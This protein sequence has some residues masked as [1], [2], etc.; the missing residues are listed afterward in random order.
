MGGVIT[1]AATKKRGRPTIHSDSLKEGMS[2]M[3]PGL[4]ERSL[5]NL[6]FAAG[7][8]DVAEQLLGKDKASR[9]FLHSPDEPCGS[10]LYRGQ[11]ILEQVGRMKLQDGYSDND[12]KTIMGIALRLRD[13][14][15]TVRDVERW[16]RNGRTTGVF[17]SEA[18]TENKEG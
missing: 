4:S 2:L 17:F 9:S 18:A 11:G 1:E 15:W 3:F 12:C 10:K 5:V 14:G 7:G 16:I 13:N 6:Y 8:Y